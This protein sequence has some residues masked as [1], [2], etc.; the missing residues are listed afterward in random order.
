VFWWGMLAIAV[1]AV[2]ALL[3]LFHWILTDPE[4][5]PAAAQDE[6]RAEQEYR[7]LRRAGKA[8]SR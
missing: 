8:P 2:A 1:T 4:A 3:G 6:F 5:A 7:A